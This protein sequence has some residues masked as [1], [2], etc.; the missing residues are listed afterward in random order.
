MGKGAAIRLLCACVLGG[1]LQGCYQLVHTAGEP[2]A[3][4][5]G[6]I[7]ERASDFGDVLAELGPPLSVTALEGG[8]A[9]LYEHSKTREW[10][11]GVSIAFPIERFGPEV[12]F[13]L[14][15]LTLAR[16]AADMQTLIV[17]FDDQ[18]KILASGFLDRDQDL[19]W[20]FGLTPPLATRDLVGAGPSH[21][22]RHDRWGMSLLRHLQYTLNAS[23][24]LA[25]GTHGFEQSDAP[26]SVGQR[27]L[28]WNDP[29]RKSS[30]EP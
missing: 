14:P 20:G 11:L 9:F 1:S 28:E 29:G 8:F 7:D 26:T 13:P 23:Q 19:G 18:G 15:K 16:G 2:I 10:Q 30:S 25:S 21:P 22:R 12:E 24:D 6:G 4:R 5:V 17:E 3:A 27:T